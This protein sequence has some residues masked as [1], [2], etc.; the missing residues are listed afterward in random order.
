VQASLAQA[1][2]DGRTN[3]ADADKE[4]LSFYGVSTTDYLTW[5]D[6]DKD[7]GHAKCE[8]RECEVE[9]AEHNRTRFLGC[10]FAC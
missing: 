9:V 2:Q 3:A 6:T 5:R 8:R 7:V 4:W 10:D 1:L